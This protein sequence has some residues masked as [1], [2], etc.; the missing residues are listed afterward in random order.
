MDLLGEHLAERSAEHGEV[1]AEHEDL[2]TVDRSPTRDDAIGEGPGVLDPEAVGPVA[3]EHVELDERARVEEQFD[4]LAGGELAPLV[5]ALDRGVAPRVQRL[6]AQIGELDEAFLDRMRSDRVDR[7]LVTVQ[8]L[9]LGSALEVFFFGSSHRA[10]VTG[11]LH[12]VLA[13]TRRGPTGKG[14]WGRRGWLVVSL[15]MER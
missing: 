3:G 9:R 8:R 7:A 1:L 5:L 2:A 11:G 4:P 6:F 10:E 15:V 13:P 12:D 14:R